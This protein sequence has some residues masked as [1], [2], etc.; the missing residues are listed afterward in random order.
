MG[1]SKK[2][3]QLLAEVRARLKPSQRESDL[4]ERNT[5]LADDKRLQGN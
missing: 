4:A 3:Q 5:D 1:T 2:I